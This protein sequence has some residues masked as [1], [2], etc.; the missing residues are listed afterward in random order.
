MMENFFPQLHLQFNEK[1]DFCI[2]PLGMARKSQKYIYIYTYKYVYIYIK[3]LYVYIS[4]YLQFGNGNSSL[5]PCWSYPLTVQN[6]LLKP[7]GRKVHE[8]TQDAMVAETT[9]SSSK[10]IKEVESAV[11]FPWGFRVW[12]FLLLPNIFLSTSGTSLNRRARVGL[13]WQIRLHC[14][15]RL[16]FCHFGMQH[17]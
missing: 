13:A 17:L 7:Q 16:C 8:A 2:Q 6:F 15:S 5:F 10:G 9:C 11:G 3:W 14:C 4:I 1:A 12:N